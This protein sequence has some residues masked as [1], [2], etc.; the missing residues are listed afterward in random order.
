MSQASESRTVVA[1]I[2]AII[3]GVGELYLNNIEKGVLFLVVG[4]VLFVASGIFFPIG[5][6]AVVFWLYTIYQTY[7]DAR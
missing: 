6:I 4:V 1:L 7:L 5:I 3:P 2:L